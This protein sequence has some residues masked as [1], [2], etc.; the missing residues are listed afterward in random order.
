M[1][2]LTWHT[3][4]KKNIYLFTDY[5]AT[6][7]TSELLRVLMDGAQASNMLTSDGAELSNMYTHVQSSG[8]DSHV[9]RAG[10]LVRK[11][12]LNP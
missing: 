9:K 2:V 12:Q 1:K 6:S 11:F 10:M 8:G 3:A 5:C 7:E 4:T